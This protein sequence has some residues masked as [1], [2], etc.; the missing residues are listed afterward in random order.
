[1]IEKTVNVFMLV[2]MSLFLLFGCSM[3]A[4]ASSRTGS[5]DVRSRVARMIDEELDNILPL[6]EKDGITIDDEGRALS[7]YTGEEIVQ[8]TIDAGGEEYINFTY[9]VSIANSKE[10]IMEAADSLLDS[11]SKAEIEGIMEK[12]EALVEKYVEEN[13]RYMT[14]TQKKAFFKDL[15]K[16]VVRSVV[17]L[18]AGIIYSCIPKAVVWGKVTAACA[19][20][21]AAGI[22]ANGVLTIVEYWDADPDEYPSFF[23]WMESMQEESYTAWATAAGMIATGNACKRSP[24]ITGIIIVAFSLYKV[25]DD[26]KPM[27]EKYGGVTLP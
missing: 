20:A 27:L 16:M 6:L 23:A 4:A 2:F 19:V 24:V 8:R 7:S 22:L 13:S 18:A 1:M 21:V 10:E 12:E 5:G 15:R 17:L 3:E 25:L 9:A 14:S 26:I 11:E